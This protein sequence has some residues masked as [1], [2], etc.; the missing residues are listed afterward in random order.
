MIQSDVVG[1][2]QQ[3][4]KNTQNCFKHFYFFRSKYFV[5]SK[6]Y[7]LKTSKKKENP[8]NKNS[9]PR[10]VQRNTGKKMF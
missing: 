3:S 7:S 9:N 2:E 6:Y 10:D 5:Y 1:M 4:G 8:L